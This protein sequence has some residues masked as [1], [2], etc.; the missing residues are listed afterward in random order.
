[1]NEEKTAM[2][3]PDSKFVFRVGE[4]L[5]RREPD[6]PFI[7]PRIDKRSVT[8]V[9]RSQDVQ[10]TADAEVLIVV[11]DPTPSL[12]RLLGQTLLVTGLIVNEEGEF[13]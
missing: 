1:M 12:I 6:D 11:K 2:E 7:A 5:P 8:L 10:F 9:C 3:A 4:P 13:E